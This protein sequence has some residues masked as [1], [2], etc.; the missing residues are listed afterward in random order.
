K[1]RPGVKVKFA[2]I[3]IN[4]VAGYLRPAEFY[5]SASFYIGVGFRVAYLRLLRDPIEPNIY[6]MRPPVGVYLDGSTVA[7]DHVRRCPEAFQRIAELA[8]GWRDVIRLVTDPDGIIK[9]AFERLDRQARTI[10]ANT[11]NIILDA[12]INNR[13]DARHLARIER[14]INQLFQ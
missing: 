11:D 9:R 6:H 4:Q 12:D 7:S 14:V 13:L 8:T 3:V 2:R 10:V 1:Q 5:K